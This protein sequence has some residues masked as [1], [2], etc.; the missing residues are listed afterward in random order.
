[1]LSWNVNNAFSQNLPI[2]L[3]TEVSLV[4]CNWVVD[5]QQ[6]ITGSW[7]CLVNPVGFKYVKACV[8]VK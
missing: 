7:A 5:H 6:E 1:M 8:V 2:K 4:L 3:T